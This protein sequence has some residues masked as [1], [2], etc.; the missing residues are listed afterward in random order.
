ME[1]GEVNIGVSPEFP[2]LPPEITKED[3]R[4]VVPKKG[5]VVLVQGINEQDDRTDPNSPD[6]GKLTPEG[7]KQAAKKAREFFDTVFKELSSKDREKVAIIVCASDAALQ[8][9]RGRSS[10]QK[11]AVETGVK[12]LEGIR[13]SMAAHEIDPTLLLND[14]EENRGEPIVMEG[15]KDL[16]LWDNREFLE[17]LEK[18]Y[19]DDHKLWVNYE[20]DNETKKERKD[21]K[22]EGPHNIAFRTRQAMA[23]TMLGVR[24]YLK[25]HPDSRV[26]VWTIG[27]YDNLAPYLKCYVLKINPKE[28]Y[29]PMQKGAGITV[30]ID[31]EEGTAETII[32][33]QTH[34]VLSLLREPF[35]VR[36][37][38][39]E[40]G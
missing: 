39:P 16:L 35:P 31:P 37:P 32:G 4:P 33:G 36:E 15:Y 19:P 21:M 34:Q 3:I 6:F 20:A 17:S 2:S 9:P 29:I 10:P 5:G 26:F 23:K 18:K 40:Q 7:A 8:M 13:G 30:E 25:D 14:A 28:N 1:T 11:R 12:V 24:E 38:F 27:M 22:V